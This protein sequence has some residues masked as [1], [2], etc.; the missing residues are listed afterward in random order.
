MQNL[1]EKL[2]QKVEV[3][4]SNK[5][6]VTYSN[7]VCEASE[8]VILLKPQ[9]NN[10]PSSVI[11]EFEISM[12]EA[13]ERIIMLQSFIKEIMISNV[14][15][16]LIPRCDKPSLF[17]SGAEKLCDIFGFSKHIEVLNRIEDWEKGLFHYEVKSILINKRT[18][19][20]E[21]E[22]IGCCNNRERKFKTQDSF[23]IINTI[24]KMAKK[25]AL[26]DAVLSA[27]RSSGIFTQDIEDFEEEHK[28]PVNNLPNKENKSQSNKHNPQNKNYNTNSTSK[29]LI[30][31]NQQNEIFSVIAQNKLPVENI[32][33]FMKEK[34]RVTES[35]ML[36]YEQAD[37][38]INFLK[39]YITI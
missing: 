13:K 37:D 14:D 25:R 28:N 9:E 29:K 34:Y 4:E 23:S 33:L 1:K 27:T 22:G 15:Y 20:I 6:K 12:N 2:L 7:T 35:K 26:I 38:F 18:G 5:P 19:F 32:K 30:N 3:I 21:A 39:A 17:K 11:P 36:S 16:G 8:N 24:L 10:K 31:K